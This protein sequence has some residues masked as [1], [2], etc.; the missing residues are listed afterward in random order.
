MT[1]ALPSA[2]AD[3]LVDEQERAADL[4]GFRTEPAVIEPGDTG[5]EPAG[6]Q[7]GTTPQPTP[8]GGATRRGK[9]GSR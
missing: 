1:T 8:Y 3:P 9:G 4:S 7:G 5:A 2:G 6:P